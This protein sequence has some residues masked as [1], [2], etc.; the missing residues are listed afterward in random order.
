MVIARGRG[1]LLR[2]L[3]LAILVL[4]CL[5]MPAACGAGGDVEIEVRIINLSQFDFTEVSIGNQTYGDITTG[6]TSDYK[7]VRTSLRYAVVKLTA[8]GRK[9]TG[10]TLYL[11]NRRR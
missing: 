2:P 7:T 10:Q 5:A 3:G 6:A 1:N 9:V 8:D 11:R 4:W